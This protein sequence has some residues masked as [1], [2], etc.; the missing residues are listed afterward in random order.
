MDPSLEFTVCGIWWDEEWHDEVM[1]KIGHVFENVSFHDYTRLMKT[2]EGRG[3][4][5][6][7]RSVA[8]EAPTTIFRQVKNVLAYGR[9]CAAGDKRIGISFD[10]WNVWYAW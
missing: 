3:R 7:F 4:P 10:E 5:R 8:A 2:F 6:R 9:H 1:A